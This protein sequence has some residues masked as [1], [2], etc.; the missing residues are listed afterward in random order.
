VN[1]V[2]VKGSGKVCVRYGNR[3]DIVAESIPK[4]D[5]KYIFDHWNTGE[6]EPTL[7]IDRAVE[8]KKLVAYYKVCYYVNVTSERGSASGSG[9]YG[10]GEKA[11]ITVSPTAIGF[12]VKEVFDHWEVNGERYVENSSFTLKVDSPKTVVAKWRTDYSETLLLVMVLVAYYLAAQ[13]IRR[14][15]KTR[16]RERQKRAGETPSV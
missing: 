9:W 10:Y 1:G 3:V 4:V 12:L 8:S 2:I 14:G 5:I 6:R 15:T 16:T 13:T 7:K 11:N